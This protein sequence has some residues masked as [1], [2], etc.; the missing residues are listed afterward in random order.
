MKPEYQIFE[1]EYEGRKL[2]FWHLVGGN[3]EIM[4]ASEG[5]TTKQHAE[6]SVER[7]KTVAA[8]AKVAD[9]TEEA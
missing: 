3:G 9:F 7:F 4:C 2:W 1:S 8:D 6:R 5:Y